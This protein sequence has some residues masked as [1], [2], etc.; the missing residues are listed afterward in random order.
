MK[1][2]IAFLMVFY[3]GTILHAQLQ[4]ND[5]IKVVSVNGTAVNYVAEITNISGNAFH[6]NFSHSGS[7]YSFENVTPSS[8]F[9]FTATVK[10]ST[11]AYRKGDVFEFNVNR[12]NYAALLSQS[13]INDYLSNSLYWFTDHI[14]VVVKFPDGKKYLAGC[15]KMPDGNLQVQFF[16]SNS[17]Y[18]VNPTTMKVTKTQG[19]GYLVGTK[20]QMFPALWVKAKNN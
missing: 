3:L 17:F 6:C 15:N 8:E 9:R 7:T 19:G 11:G 1:K 13:N 10:T 18:T 5:F 4:K 16:H 20:M 2:L 12:P 14:R